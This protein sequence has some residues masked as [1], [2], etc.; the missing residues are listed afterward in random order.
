MEKK[1]VLLFFIFFGFVHL[2]ADDETVWNQGYQLYQEKKYQEAL[3]HFLQIQDTNAA[4]C[5]MIAEC[6]QSLGREVLA[7]GYTEKAFVRGNFWQRKR[8]LEK[9]ESVF[10]RGYQVP[11]IAKNTRD[12]LYC[13][14]LSFSIIFLQFLFLILFCLFLFVNV[15]RYF[16]FCKIGLFIILCFV[17]L[18]MNNMHQL[19]RPRGIVS[20]Q[21][22][23][24]VVPAEDA[25]VV[26]ELAVGEVVYITL[27]QERFFKVKINHEKGWIQIQDVFEIA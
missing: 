2:F 21:S 18:C 3:S 7:K 13:L 8:I 4:L 10:F 23:L 11:E 24:T 5:M 9:Q 16:L 15:R 17:V 22:N 26:R 25:P 19:Y 12:M 20:V 6:Y 1:I 27:R 14:S